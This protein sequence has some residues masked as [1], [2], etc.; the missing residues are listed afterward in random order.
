MNMCQSLYIFTQNGLMIFFHCCLSTVAKIVQ[1]KF[2]SLFKL[3]YVKFV[4]MC[5]M[6]S[7]QI[8][9]TSEYK[10]NQGGMCG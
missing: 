6:L 8:F 1:Y 5:S 7:I 10:E 9:L 2:F 3:L 4:Y